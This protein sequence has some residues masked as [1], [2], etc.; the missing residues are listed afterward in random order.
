M[1]DCLL[2]PDMSENAARA[3]LE[4]LDPDTPWPTEV[5]FLQA[6]VAH[7]SFFREELRKVTFT[8]ASLHRL[9]VNAASL[10]KFRWL[11]ND[12]RYRH[13]INRQ[14][15]VLLP[16]RRTTSNESLHHEVNVWFRE[17]VT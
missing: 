16:S 1:R 5:D 13:S 12:A 9:I 6:L 4:T 14:E 15:L 7:F 17:T 3:V 10:A 2:E 11:L 8:G